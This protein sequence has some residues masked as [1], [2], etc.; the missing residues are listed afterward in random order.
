MRDD[1]LKT[2]AR[3]ILHPIEVLLDCDGQAGRQRA[4][5]AIAPAVVLRIRVVGIEQHALARTESLLREPGI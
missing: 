3:P 2:A 1:D 4:V 5:D